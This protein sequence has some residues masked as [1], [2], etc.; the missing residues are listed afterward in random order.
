MELVRQSHDLSEDPGSKKTTDL[1]VFSMKNL[2]EQS[3]L[4]AKIERLEKELKRVKDKEHQY[5]HLFEKSP[6]MIY[7]IDRQ[8]NF[9][10]INQAG[11]ELMGY[12]SANEI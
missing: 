4:E 10:N 11:V 5:R 9:L 8:G 7:A 12:D 2:K 3:P 1:I 6:I